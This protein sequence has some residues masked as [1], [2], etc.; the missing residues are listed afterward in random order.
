MRKNG[1]KFVAGSLAMLWLQILFFTIDLP[2][3]CFHLLSVSP[4]AC[5]AVT[6]GYGPRIAPTRGG[7]EFHDGVDL[8]APQG[9]PI[10]A[11]ANGTVLEVGFGAGYGN[12]VVIQHEWKVKS[13]YAHC[14]EI[15]VEE[16]DQVTRG[17]TVAAVGSTGNS[18]GSHL[19]LHVEYRDRTIPPRRA[20]RY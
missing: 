9:A 5:G 17:E 14:S 3:L 1:L 11:A 18:T 12:Y 10:A 19:H 6:S 20:V 13:L 16:G 2:L 7:L 15:F 8:A 4:L